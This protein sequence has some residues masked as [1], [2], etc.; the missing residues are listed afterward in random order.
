MPAPVI[1]AV[2]VALGTAAAGT[3]AAGTAAAG[4]QPVTPAAA[5]AA[6]QPAAGV[7]AGRVLDVTRAPLAGAVVRVLPG[8][9]AADPAVPPTQ[10]DAAGRFVLRGVRAGV[11]QLEVRRLG[12]TPRIIGDVVVRAGQPADLRIVLDPAAVALAGVTVRP[13]DF[14]AVA[15]PATPVST[16]GFS[17]EQLRR[18]PGVQE[19][20][21]RAL[22]VLPGVAPTTEGRNDLVVRGGAPVEML[23]LVDGLEVPS[24]S[25]FGA[26]GS[27][28]GAAGLLPT[29]FV[30]DASLSTGGFGA[31]YGDRAS[32]VV[33]VA[34]R[35]GTRERV[36]SQLTVSTLDA[37]AFAEGPL[38][39][40]GSFLAG[41]RQSYLGPVLR[42]L[43]ANFL[44]TFTDLTLRAV[45]RPSARDK[46][47]WFAVAG[48][49][50]VT[51]NTATALDRY[52]ARDLVAPNETQVFTGATW[53]RALARGRGRGVTAV[54]VGRTVQ[55]FAT[56]QVGALV[57][58]DPVELIFRAHTTESEDQ[59]RATLAW[60]PDAA[61]AAGHPGAVAAGA[62]TWEVGV[63]AK[64]ADRLH[65]VLT[66]PGFLRRDAA[67]REHPLATDTTF[68]A[69][70]AGAYAQVDTRVGPGVRAA[71]GVRADG[72]AFLGGAARVAPRASLT[73]VPNARG[74]VTLAGGRYWQAPQPI[75]L[76][77]DPANRP[78]APGGG[79]RP[80]R[81]DHLV[82]AW[83]RTLGPGLQVRVEGYAKWYAD[84]PARVFRPRAVLQPGT[85]DNALTDIPF[86]LEPLASA[87]TGR[88]RGVD[89]L[90]Q[91]PLSA[92]PGSG[93]VYGSVYGLAALSLSRATF[94]ALQGG[95]LPSAY[96]VPMIATV[97]A[98]W[99]PGGLGGAWELS[100][101]ARLA[102]GAPTPRFA[103]EGPFYAQPDPAT[104]GEGPR[105]TRFFSVDARVNRRFTRRSG[106]PVLAYLEVQDAT[107]RH[108][109]Y[110]EEWSPYYQAPFRITTL[111]WLPSAGLHWAF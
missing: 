72:Y 55:A 16:A 4:A 110:S 76:A 80:F 52:A 50:T 106:R 92:A 83:Q 18:A 68:T 100:T 88:V 7:V 73:W 78:S 47:A 57:Y 105:R 22:S 70:R 79:V 8:P 66:L 69:F 54:T 82:L 48:R 84:F 95:P 24:I 109:W 37:G 60:T 43:G 36:A 17:T 33:D 34:L 38:G 102:S 10:T 5:P 59:L 108:N 13:T 104:Y 12:Y 29:D 61:R 71:L 56:E 30:R 25:H 26:Q 21:V 14:R 53:R 42:A 91:K 49:S 1:P 86:G 51:V 40:S 64:Y 89:L 15:T 19:D 97:V 103:T 111:G 99:R 41:V 11:V 32:G 27:T 44:P 85:F 65:Y 45:T 90:V 31:R 96:D 2:V 58:G 101:R 62:T 75:W 63:V 6:A 46:L 74:A 87:G 67:G 9:G 39:A 93:A 107:D 81:A 77:G 3:A 98:G 20:V 28:G 23:F 94:R 35:E